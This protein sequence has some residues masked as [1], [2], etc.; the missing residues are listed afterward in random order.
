MSSINETM[1]AINEAC[2]GTGYSC[3]TV[4]WDDAAR[5]SV[6]GQ[7]SSLG[8]NITDVRLMSKNKKHLFTVRPG[9][10]NEKLGVL[11]SDQLAA[12][13]GN[14]TK[15]GELKPVTLGTLLRGAGK[16]FSALG[17]GSDLDL[18]APR[19]EK[20][21]VRF[22]TTFLPVPEGGKTIEFA[23]EHYN[24]QTH[25]S[26]I[27]RNALLVCTTQ[28]AALQ[29]DGPG[30]QKVFLHKL[31]AMGSTHKVDRDWMEAESTE[32]KVG[33]AQ[34]ETA[35]QRDDAHKRGKATASVIGTKA[36]GTRFN[37]LATV[38]IPLKQAPVIQSRGTPSSFSF[39]PP[40]Y[41]SEEPVA[42]ICSDGGGGV[43]GAS[44][45]LSYPK[46]YAGMSY[47]PKGVMRATSVRGRGR[48]GLPK[49]T[50][51]AA[52]VSHGS[53]YDR[54]WELPVKKLERDADQNITVTIVLYNTVAN[55]VP[56]TEDVK[57]AIADLENLYEQCTQSGHLAD[58]EF[59]FA[60]AGELTV[61]DLATIKRKVDMTQ[62]ETEKIA[63]LTKL[64]ES[65]SASISSIT[66]ELSR[67][68]PSDKDLDRILRECMKMQ[69]NADEVIRTL[70]LQGGPVAAHNAFPSAMD[71]VE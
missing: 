15:S 55:G 61:H 31:S 49:G 54:D 45:T 46:S 19:D 17:V 30:S 68:S 24:Y 52:R 69:K 60:K 20:V 33:G 57:A 7:L 34:T 25:S 62:Q 67:A 47:Q 37:V 13:I 41:L 70:G 36:M 38:Q 51:S 42:S 50:S 6:G 8:P 27:P 23:P 12:V 2:A 16:H 9:N 21:T 14:Y 44:P 63:R 71:T 4:S 11:S 26:D 35:A 5:A 18:S 64:T 1:K 39:G 28:G 10:F 32:F 58:K 43:F 48:G 3:K 66:E 53:N 40:C 29:T 59:E 22:Q 65:T 56:T